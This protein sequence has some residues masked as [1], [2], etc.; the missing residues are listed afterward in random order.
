MFGNFSYSHELTNIIG[1]SSDTNHNLSKRILL[2]LESDK[3]PL[4]LSDDNTGTAYE[5]VI[6]GIIERY[7][8][9]D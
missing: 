8:D 1:G 9:N 6:R 2:L 7:I 3:I 4:N 5:R